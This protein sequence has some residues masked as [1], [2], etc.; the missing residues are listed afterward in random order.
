MD[1][2]TCR[3]K[4]PAAPTAERPPRRFCFCFCAPATPRSSRPAPAPVTLL[5][6]PLSWILILALA[7]PCIPSSRRR[8]MAD[9]NQLEQ[10]YYDVPIV[11]RVWTTAAVITSVLVQCQVVTPFQLFF[12]VSSVWGKRQVREALSR[13]RVDGQMHDGAGGLTVEAVLASH[14]DLSL[15][16]S[17]LA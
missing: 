11:T 8:A 9:V 14:H 6:L 7:R 4:L 15:L 10:W 5:D 3:R 17:T 2:M 16:W 12:S 13:R 1:E